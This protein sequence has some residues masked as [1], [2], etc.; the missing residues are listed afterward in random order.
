MAE[1]LSGLVRAY[2]AGAAALEAVAKMEHHAAK[3]R[4]VLEHSQS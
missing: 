4:G 3:V 1:D 2:E